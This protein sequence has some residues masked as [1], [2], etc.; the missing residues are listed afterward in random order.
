MSVIM[1]MYGHFLYRIKSRWCNDVKEKWP[2]TCAHFFTSSSPIFTSM[3]VLIG[4][5][6]AINAVSNDNSFHRC[7]RML[8]VGKLLLLLPAFSPKTSD[9]SGRFFCFH[10]RSSIVWPQ[11]GS[12]QCGLIIVVRNVAQVLVLH[13]VCDLIFCRFFDLPRSVL[14]RKFR[15][16]KIDWQ[17]RQC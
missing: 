1:V 5:K 10:P 4:S 11:C 16:K 17:R 3:L 8:W 12:S 14:G 9:A 13:V 6:L 15:K 7:F 2:H